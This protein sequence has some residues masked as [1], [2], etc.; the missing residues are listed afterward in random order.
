MSKIHSK[1]H[2]IQYRAKLITRRNDSRLNSN[3]QLQI[4]GWRA[5]C[6]IQV[7]LDH[8]ACVEYLTKYAA[9]GE[10]R[11]PLLKTAFNSIVSH[12]QS[13]GNPLKAMKKVIMKTLG[14]RDY[15]AQEIMHQLLSL[16]LHSSSFHVIPISLNGSRRVKTSA[17]LE[18]GQACS[19]NSDFLMYMLIALIMISQQM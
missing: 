5:N 16:K 18:E 1:S 15:A 3:Q 10:P 8:Y 4:Q 13:N 19:Q 9:K 12:V 17:M 6:D 14:E 11:S 2:E 7:V